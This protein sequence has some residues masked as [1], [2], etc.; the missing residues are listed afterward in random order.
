MQAKTADKW[1]EL[2]ADAGVPSSKVKKISEVVQDQQAEAIQM[3]TDVPHSTI[4]N[5]KLPRLP[6]EL[7]TSPVT[8]QQSPP[9]IGENTK[10]Y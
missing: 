1:V 4:T 6:F 5:F 10:R 8:I 2:L 3:W 9:K 7:S